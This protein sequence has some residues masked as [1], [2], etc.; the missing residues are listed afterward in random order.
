[1]KE[2]EDS[3]SNQGE[4]QEMESIGEEGFS[5]VLRHQC[6]NFQTHKKYSIISIVMR[7]KNKYQ[8][9]KK[10]HKI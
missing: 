10:V 3:M 6:Q 9:L 2:D 4:G 8:N 7:K 5:N 1:M